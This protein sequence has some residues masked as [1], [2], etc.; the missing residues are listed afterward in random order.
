MLKVE[1]KEGENTIEVQGNVVEI[2]TDVGVLLKS[3]YDGLND[4][5]VKGFF[6]ENLKCFV[7]DGIYKMSSEELEK[8]NNEN[9]ERIL[10]KRKKEEK[11]EVAKKEIVEGLNELIK[12]LEKVVKQ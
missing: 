11:K 12:L 6:E 9:L 1:I 8:L 7:N 2:L 5:G 10:N 3:I 4:N